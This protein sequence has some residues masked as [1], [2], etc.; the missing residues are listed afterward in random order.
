MDPSSLL[1]SHMFVDRSDQ[2]AIGLTFAFDASKGRFATI[3]YL[4]GNKSLGQPPNA[5]PLSIWK[6]PDAKGLDIKYRDLASG[7]VEGTYT[8]NELKPV[9]FYNSIPTAPTKSQ[10][11][12]QHRQPTRS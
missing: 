6:S 1:S 7:V 2:Q 8:L 4:S 10:R 9:Y 3:T 12:V 5:G 11:E